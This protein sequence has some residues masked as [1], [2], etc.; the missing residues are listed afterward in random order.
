MKEVTEYLAMNME[1]E[2]GFAD[3]TSEV[4]DVAA[5]SGVAAGICLINVKHIRRARVFVS[6]YSQEY[7]NSSYESHLGI[8]TECMVVCPDD[9]RSVEQ[10]MRSNYNRAK[11]S[12]INTAMHDV[13]DYTRVTACM[14]GHTLPAS[15]WPHLDGLDDPPPHRRRAPYREAA[16]AIAEGR[17][18]LERQERIFYGGLDGGRPKRV[19]VKVVGE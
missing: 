4:R 1:P 19:L 3:I 11:W 18:A 9:R 2:G 10:I 16:V 13:L 17:L 14:H 6:E 7:L 12:A 5:Q 15:V 8:S